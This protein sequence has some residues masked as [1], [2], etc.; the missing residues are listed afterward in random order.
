MLVIITDR[1]LVH[2]PVRDMEN[3]ANV[4]RITVTITKG[5]RDV[6][7]RKKQK[8]LMTEVSKTLREI[9]ACYNLRSRME[10]R[11]RFLTRFTPGG[12]TGR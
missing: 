6:S 5:F 11:R 2:M 8:Q 7:F 10:D 12:Q 9:T 3:V 1:V 4:W